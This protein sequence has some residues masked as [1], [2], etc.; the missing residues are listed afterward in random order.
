MI[1]TGVDG[2]KSFSVRYSYLK[3]KWEPTERQGRKVCIVPSDLCF[4]KVEDAFSK[5]KHEIRSLY[6]LYVEEKFGDVKWDTSLYRDK[7]FLGVYRDFSER[8]CQ[9]VELEVFALARVLMVLGIDG[10]VL[11]LGRRKSTLVEV[12]EGLL[13]SYRVVLK[14]GNYITE[15]IKLKKGLSVEEANRLK[16]TKGLD[17]EEIREGLMDIFSSISLDTNIPILLSGGL[18]RLKGIKDMFKSVI[19]NPYCE[20]ELTSAFGA[21]LRYILKNPYP[22]FI[23]REL[24]EEE[25]KRVGMSVGIGAFLFLFVYLGMGK[26]LSSGSLKYEER[27][28]FKAVFPNTPMVALYDQVRSKVSTGERY[29]VTKKISKLQHILKEG[30]KVYSIEYSD[31]VLTVKGEGKEDL[32]MGIGAKRIKRTPTGSLEFEVEIR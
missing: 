20:S 2:N 10:Y 9:E 23:K 8:D 17:V 18:S 5:K 12:Q 29:Q 27:E 19:E 31:G 11:D 21:S 6:S 22:D 25:L 16:K 4:I 1:Y 7:A 28:R 32:V 24:S 15:V 26:L 30:M 13:K 3:R 14:G